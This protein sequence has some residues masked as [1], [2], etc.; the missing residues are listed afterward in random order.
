MKQFLASLVVGMFIFGCNTKSEFVIEER[1]ATVENQVTENNTELIMA[2]Q[3]TIKEL[4]S[5]LAKSMV[6]IL[7][8]Y[9]ELVECNE[10]VNVLEE[11]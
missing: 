10:L 5:D 7:E 9:K 8:L 11:I 2:Q 1:V 6:I 3:K 4:K